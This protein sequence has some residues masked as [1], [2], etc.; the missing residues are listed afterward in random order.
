MPGALLGKRYYFNDHL[1]IQL[2][3]TVTKSTHTQSNV[4]T[5]KGN[6]DQALLCYRKALSLKPP[7]EEVSSVLLNKASIELAIDRT[8]EA[9]R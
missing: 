8:E 3:L 4:L 1:I 2:F 6:L 5:A 9:I 7:K